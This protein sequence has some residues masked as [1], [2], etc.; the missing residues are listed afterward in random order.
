MNGLTAIP[1]MKVGHYTNLDA[2]TGCTVVLCE[3]GAVGGVDVRGG[4]P[5]TRGTDLLRPTSLVWE[6]HGIV[7]SGGSAFGL[8]TASGA[9]R[10]LEERGVGFRAM[11]SLVPIVAAAILFDL[12]LVTDKVRPG[13]DEGYEACVSAAEGPVAEGSVGAGTG[14]TVGKLLGWDRAVKGGLGTAG[15]D[16]GGGLSV[17]AVVAVNALGDVF[18]PDSGGHVAGPRRPDGNGMVD[19]FDEITSPEFVSVKE[20]IYSNT[21]IGVVATNA[22]LSKEQANRLASVAHDGVAMAVRPAHTMSDGDTMFALAT[23]GPETQAGQADV[24]RVYA[25][26]VRCVSTAIVR[27][28]KEARGLGGIPAVSEL[29]DHG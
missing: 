9:V 27:G 6:V 11:G 4:A 2:A 12:G 8:D 7:L 16:L 26:A 28:V 17:A 22:R 1:G 14:A 24:V 20:T 19:G 21:T 18:D 29:A 25:A 15:L 3:A 23:G 13:L 10:Y 5:G